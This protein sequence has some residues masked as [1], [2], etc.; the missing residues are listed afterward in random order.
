MFRTPNFVDRPGHA[1]ILHLDLWWRGRNLLCDPGTYLYDGEPGWDN[2]LISADVH[3]TVTVDGADPMLRAGLFLW[4]DWPNTTTHPRRV[5][6]KNAI[7]CITAEHDGYGRLG[8]KHRRSVLRIA[9]EAWV[10][11]DD[12]IGDGRHDIALHWLAPDLRHEVKVGNGISFGDWRLDLNASSP[13]NF[14]IVRAGAVVHGMAAASDR[15]KYRGWISR[16]YAQ[17]EPGISVRLSCR[18]DLPIRFVSVV[19]RGDL[20]PEINTDAASGVNW[21]TEFDVI[22]A[23]EPI[24]SAVHLHS[25]ARL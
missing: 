13:A 10:I 6:G 8:L 20:L 21:K 2:E 15:T 24:R 19:T 1:D 5:A 11:V 25:G 7:E 9:D 17:R 23:T 18:A 4:L 3:N 12:V 14:D 22:G 16:A